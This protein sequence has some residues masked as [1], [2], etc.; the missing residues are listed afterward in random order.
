MSQPF[1]PRQ[2]YYRV[3]LALL[4]LTLLTVAVAFVDLGPLNTVIALTIA[5]VKA[6]LVLLYFMH[7]RYSSG[8]TWIVLGAGIFW[9]THLLILTLS[10]YL[11]RPWLPVAGW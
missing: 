11:T 4:G 5:V 8:L 1:V 9:L 7:L 3:F 2:L 10:D 6:L